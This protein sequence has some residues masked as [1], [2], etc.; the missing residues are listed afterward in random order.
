MRLALVTSLLPPDRP[1]TG[2]EIATASIVGALKDAGHEVVSF[3][4]RRP[5]DRAEE[6]QDVVC[7][8]RFEIENARAGALRKVAW[9]AGGLA[10]GLPV[11][12]AKLA[13]QGIDQLRAALAARGPFAG[14]IING[15]PVAGA[16]GALMREHPSILVAHNQE[17]LSARQNADDAQ[18]VLRRLYLREAKLLDAIERRA[19]NDARFIWFLSEE[20]RSAFGTETAE[21]SMVMPLLVEAASRLRE[22]END[23]DV[24]LIGTW[25][26]RPNLIGLNWFLDKVVPKLAPEM[27]IAVAGRHPEGITAPANVALLGRVPDATA[28]VSSCRAI[29]LASRA[30]TGV[31]LKTIETFQMGMP[32]VATRL[33][34]RGIGALPPNCLVA[35]DPASFAASIMKLVSDLKA[36]RAT[37][38][39]GKEFAAGCQREMRAAALAGVMA[40]VGA[41]KHASGG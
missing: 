39:D 40:L 26:W 35:D 30:G 7:L 9:I 1:D 41:G 10:R 15:A 23:Y 27:R 20:D 28:F 36:G 13:E 21:K 2:F 24:G 34:V 17:G 3:G 25:T 31:Q 4:Y 29:A 37:R 12:S 14:V 33:S 38:T 6:R 11:I 32:C 22:V 16:F 8:G 18:G 19:I 5:G